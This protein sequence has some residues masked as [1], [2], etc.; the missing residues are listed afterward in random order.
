MSN[1]GLRHI[2]GVTTLPLDGLWSSLANVPVEDKLSA[3]LEYAGCEFYDDERKFLRNFTVSLV[4]VGGSPVAYEKDSDE[5]IKERMDG[6]VQGSHSL[7]GAAAAFSYL[8][9]GEKA[10]DSLYEQVISLGHF[11][12]AHTVQANFIVA[13]ITEATEVELSLQR[14]IVHLS[15]LTNTRTRIQNSPP[16]A[17]RNP[18][19]LPGVRRV[20]A[21]INKLRAEYDENASADTLEIINGFYPVNKATILML[22]GDLSNMRKLIQ[23]RDDKGKERELR[24][25]ANDLRDQLLT[26]WPELFKDKE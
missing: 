13:G 7:M 14:D 9:S 25:V 6:F 12:V 17:V 19:D 3:A 1:S 21:E 23:L 16:I 26:L 10:I 4:G 24:E 20:Q 8:N 11:S 18:D 2:E 5:T 15:K 22:S